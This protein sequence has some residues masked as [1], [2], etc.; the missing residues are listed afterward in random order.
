MRSLACIL[1]AMVALNSSAATHE[2]RERISYE[3]RSDCPYPWCAQ[4]PAIYRLVAPQDPALYLG[5]RISYERPSD[6]RDFAPLRDTVEDL[7]RGRTST[8]DQVQAIADWL[9]HAKQPG[10][11]QYESWPASIVD[12]WGFDPIQCEEASFLLT[13]MLRAV[14]IPAMRFLTWNNQHAAVRAFV[15]GDWIVV[16]AT[17]TSPDNSGPARVYGPDDPSV[18]AGFQERP[19]LTLQRVAMPG[20]DEPVDSFTM[21]SYEPIDESAKLDRLGLSY[22]SVTFP[23]TNRF[24]YYDSTTRLLDD[25]GTSDQRVTIL[26]HIDA[27]DGSCLNDRGSWYATPLRF[28]VPDVIWRTIDGKLP[29]QIGV[30]YPDGYIE[31]ILPACGTWR[32]NYYFSDLDLNASD[33]A[34]A[35]ADFDVGNDGG[36]VVIRPE[37]LQ[38]AEG[39]DMYFF[40]QLV[41]ALAQLPAYEQLG[42]DA[43]Q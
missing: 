33:A 29:P 28:I 3:G 23:V 40:G 37:S 31:T 25:Q 36:H 5:D 21:Y 7:V 35:Y 34:L 17:P 41:N 26:F 42:G 30:T 10:A 43:T 15:D 20:S 6:W 9:K 22:G 18:V 13:A 27:I 1:L 4:R 14:G 39:A 11:H 8:L 32:I 2:L 12:M 19:I 24:L 38:P 16:D